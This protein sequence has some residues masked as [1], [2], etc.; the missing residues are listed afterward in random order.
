MFGVL[1]FLVFFCAVSLAFFAN[2][3]WWIRVST[4]S[5]RCI[6]YFGPFT[7]QEEAIAHH[8]GYLQDL[9]MEGAQGIEYKIELSHKPKKLTVED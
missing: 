3:K 2:R 7:S 8:Q 1:L 6:Y 4:Q 5:P 9:E